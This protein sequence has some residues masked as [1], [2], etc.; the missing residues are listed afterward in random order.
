MAFAL[1]TALIGIWMIS[2]ALQG[3]LSLVGSL[4]TG[5]GSMVSRCLLGVGGLCLAAPVE[6]E[7]GVSHL[8]LIGIGVGIAAPS[9]I[10]ARRRAKAC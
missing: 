9:F 7:I 5:A 2:A 3:Y 4:G 8:A 1:T 6:G 10:L